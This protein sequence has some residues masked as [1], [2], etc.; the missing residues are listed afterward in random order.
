[1]YS[2]PSIHQRFSKEVKA[3]EENERSYDHNRNI[4]NDNRANDQDCKGC[5]C[6]HNSR[7][8]AITTTSD[9]K[10]G[11]S[12]DKIILQQTLVMRYGSSK[13]GIPECFRTSL[14]RHSN[15]RVLVV[16]D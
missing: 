1:M 11:I 2:T 4:S 3:K 16:H 10:D 14:I 6:K 8:P 12:I 5:S 7:D 15:T 13:E 9:E